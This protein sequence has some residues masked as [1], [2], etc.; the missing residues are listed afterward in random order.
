MF[1]EVFRHGQLVPAVHGSRVIRHAEPV[2][3]RGKTLEHK[4]QLKASAEVYIYCTN[5]STIYY[6]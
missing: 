6:I 5:Q 2:E 1:C 3:P 4:T